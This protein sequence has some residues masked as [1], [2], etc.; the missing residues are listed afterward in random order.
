MFGVLEN[1]NFINV[2]VVVICYFGGIKLGVGGLICVY[3]GSVVL[4]VKEIGI[5]EIK[6]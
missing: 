4:V 5:I 6:E 1:Y 2:C 3:V